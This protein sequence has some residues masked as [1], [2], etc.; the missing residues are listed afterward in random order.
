VS[1][2]VDDKMYVHSGMYAPTYTTKNSPT[3][4]WE[5]SWYVCRCGCGCVV[6]LIW[7]C[8]GG[9]GGSDSDIFVDSA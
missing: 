5:Y 1:N 6:R 2:A 8:G 7:S 4:L 9:C 3:S